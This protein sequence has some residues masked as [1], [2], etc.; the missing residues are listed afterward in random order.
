MAFFR[1]I[2]INVRG[3]IY[4]S[5]GQTEINANYLEEAPTLEQIN[6]MPGNILLEFGAP[7]CPHCQLAQ[8]IVQEELK[9]HPELTHIKLYDGKGKPL[10]RAFKVKLWPTLILLHNGLEIGRLIRPTNSGY[11]RHLFLSAH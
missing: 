2:L 6:E 8:P 9:D 1:L 10:G 7:W 4:M 5:R 11:V 3:L